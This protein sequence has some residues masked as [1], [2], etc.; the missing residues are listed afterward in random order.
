MM[1]HAVWSIPVGLLLCAASV[2]DAS[3]DIPD[4]D[5][6]WR[7]HSL[8]GSVNYLTESDLLDESIAVEQA[9]VRAQSGSAY[10]MELRPHITT[11]DA[12]IGL[13]IYLPDRWGKEQLQEQLLLTAR[14]EQ[15][16]VA[17]LEW[18]ELLAVYRDFCTY[19]MLQKQRTLYADE[20]GAVEPYLARAD[21]SVQL[22]HLSVTDRAKLYS[23]YLDLRSELDKTELDL[24]RIRKSLLLAL[25]R[26]ADLDSFAESAVVELPTRPDIR[27]LLSR[28]LDSRADFQR[29]EVQSR[30]AAAAEAA[31]RSEDGFRFKYIQPEYEIDY[32][33]GEST[34][35]LSASFVLPWGSRNP[36]IS[37]YQEQ[38]QLAVSAMALQR[39]VIEERLEVLVDT[40]QAFEKQ[41][42]ESRAFNRP[43]LKQLQ[44]DLLQMDTGMLEQLRDQLLV[45]ERLLDAA[46]RGTRAA[47]ERERIAV[48]LAEELGSLRA[49]PQD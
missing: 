37:V 3:S 38:Q 42:E 33:N 45:R 10:S 20:L 29:L 34:F 21:E 6:L 31:A 1:R 7:Q 47:Y 46:L 14:S 17:Q 13:R 15:L 40:A 4:L 48:D 39:R 12:G 23:F 25:G 9:A 49:A 8:K 19:R 16:R 36:D 22:R 24:L 28:A 26:E 44:Q 30:S 2:A 27:A 5:A 41:I 35:G 32:N 11:D 18:Q 43:L